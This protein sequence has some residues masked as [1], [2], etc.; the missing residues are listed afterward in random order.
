MVAC[1]ADLALGMT[2]VASSCLA[3][4]AAVA[5]GGVMSPTSLGEASNDS[6]ESW[7]DDLALPS[8]EP[9]LRPEVLAGE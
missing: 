1:L 5:L 6:V 9:A 2:S 7:Q 4:A 3:A 8:K